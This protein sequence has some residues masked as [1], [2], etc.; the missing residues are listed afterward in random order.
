LQKTL[1]LDILTVFGLDFDQISFN[2][3]E[4]AFTTRQLAS[5]ATSIAF[6]DFLTRACAEIKIFRFL[7]FFFAF[8]F[9]PFPFFSLQ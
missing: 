9:S 8:P 4:N 2:L 3:D 1:S 6:Y 7:N 5:L